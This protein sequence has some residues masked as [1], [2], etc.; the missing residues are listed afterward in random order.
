MVNEGKY[1]IHGAFGEYTVYT[2]GWVNT[3][4]MTACEKLH[5]KADRE[6]VHG[7]QVI[8]LFHIERMHHPSELFEGW[9][10]AQMD[11]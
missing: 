8:G 11:F 3:I 4:E 6:W 1:F 10:T 7:P 5:L 9:N 2:N